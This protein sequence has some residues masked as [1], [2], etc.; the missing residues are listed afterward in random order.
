M[1]TDVV[2][3]TALM[4]RDEEAARIVRRRHRQVLEEALSVCHGELLQYLGDG[5]LSTFPSVADAVRAAIQ[6]QSELQIEPTVPLRIGIH[7]GDISYDTQGAYGDSVNI[8]ARIQ[9]L[10]APGS[11]LLSATAR[12]EIKN[13]ADISTT[14][15]GVFELKNVTEPVEVHAVDSD[16][17]VVPTRSDV[18]ANV[19]STPAEAAEVVVRL[20]T[21]LIGRY[22]IQRELGEGGMA[23]VYLA[24]DL[25][26]ERKVALKVLKPELAAVVGA[27][28]FL[29]E[30]KTTANLQHPHVL[31]LFDSGEADGFLF[32]V[33][34]YVEGESLQ[35]RLD[36]EHQL[37]VDDAVRIASDVA[38]A[39]EY[40]HGH[41][42][43]HRDIKPANILIQAGRPVIADFGI[44]L[45]VSAGGG[46]RLTETGL[47]LGTPHYMSPEQATGDQ[48]VGPATDT[49]ALGCVLYEMLVGEPPYTGGTPQAVLARIITGTADPVTEQRR[50]VPA[51]VDAAIQRALET[52]PA[53]RF[54]A[55]Q[56][57]AK[58]LSD[59]GFRHGD[60][61][62]A[63]VATSAGPWKGVS[64]ALGIISLVF[65]LLW[66]GALYQP[67]PVAL[68]H[69]ASVLLR[70]PRGGEFGTMGLSRDG[71]IMVYEGPD[72]D[73]GSQL[74]VRRWDELGASPLPGTQ[75]GIAPSISP[76][77][78]E[79]VFLVAGDIPRRI[80]IAALGGGAPTTFTDVAVA[81]PHWATDGFIYYTDSE[82]GGISR[83][84]AQGGPK[85]V[86]TRRPEDQGEDFHL[87]AHY[88]QEGDAVLFHM[89]GPGGPQI[90]VAD[91][92]TG[93]VKSLGQVGVRP[94]YTTSGHLVFLTTTGEF[95]AAIFDPRR[96]ELTG[97]A[98]P[99]IS[100][101]SYQLQV[102][103]FALSENGTL[104]YPTGSGGARYRPVWVDRHGAATVI[105]PEWMF[106]PGIN[107][108]GLSLSPDGTGLAVTIM[109]EEA[110]DIWIK[111]LPRGPLTRLTVNG[112]LD[113][114][115]RWT[116]DG[117]VTFISGRGGTA[118]VFVR[119]ADG[120]G[121]AEPL[122]T[123]EAPVWE[124]V[125]SRDGEW[126]VARTGGAQG[127]AGGR[128]VLALRLG[129]DSVPT[130]LIV[131][132]FDEK[133]I[134]LSP[135]GRALVYESDETGRNEIYVR[136]FPDVESGKWPVSIGGGVMPLWANSG[137]EIFYVNEANEMVAAQV[138]MGQAFEVQEREVLFSIGTE[139]L[140]GQAEQYTLYD[141]AL[142]DQRFLMLHRAEVAVGELIL[143]QNFFEEL[144]ERVPN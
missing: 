14:A 101:A 6:V 20:N 79:V 40:A 46:S 13:Q 55:V 82:T 131:T 11:I 85:E 112:A 28:R 103:A 105:D 51:N 24:D 75:Q 111:Q 126:L 122:L 21:A 50:S 72:E 44:A 115:P 63:S 45:A 64:V 68:T 78:R 62:V 118:D 36:R 120:T 117:R 104:V 74:W 25:R 83:M 57:F 43:I 67:D 47:S 32:Y 100:G 96:L 139:F 31:P 3:Y 49:W 9:S 61:V 52:V 12:D 60:E 99:V 16:T 56:D 81:D 132:G 17:L 5:S 134:M 94:H 92:S 137:N 58:A 144:T 10:A 102:T 18:L 124:A 95:M 53:D 97:V 135:D 19:R 4:Q 54:T 119:T 87:G 114:R 116:R 66:A 128:D 30:I 26:H 130:P 138:R 8:A 73:G 136:P 76:D 70:E 1:F 35:E 89:Y 33:M 125:L 2:G 142:D 86:I 34:P 110:E 106:D 88:V 65:G 90:R 48:H 127:V 59:P 15:I 27:E 29:A 91:I 140:I 23:T 69:R 41:G 143:V 71:S 80:M 37:P 42:V 77:G 84:P 98:V 7:Q 93:E 113:V 39:L 22:R 121:T 123:W 38:E 107:N 129:E 109:G 141:V 108:R 133:A